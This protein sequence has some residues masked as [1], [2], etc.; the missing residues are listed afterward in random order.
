[1]MDAWDGCIL[2]VL[3]PPDLRFIYVA[4]KAATYKAGTQ[5]RNLP[6]VSSSIS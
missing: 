1:M 3:K 2:Q 6:N 5:N 4:A